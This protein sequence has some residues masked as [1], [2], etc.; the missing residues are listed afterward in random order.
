MQ[1]AR[2]PAGAL[3]N[4]KSDRLSG[5]ENDRL[6][7]VDDYKSMGLSG[8][9]DLWEQATAPVFMGLDP[10]GSHIELD[11]VNHQSG[12]AEFTRPVVAVS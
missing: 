1:D 4:A 9:Y 2:M 11:K 12:R 8:R 7:R 3:L 6:D 5:S 10:A